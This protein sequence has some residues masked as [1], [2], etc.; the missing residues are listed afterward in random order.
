MDE[1]FNPTLVR[2]KLKEDKNSEILFVF[3][4]YISAI[5]TPLPLHPS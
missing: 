3:Q 5:K 4:S 1:S 2:L